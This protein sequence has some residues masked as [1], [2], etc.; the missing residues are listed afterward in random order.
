M[1]LEI[2][3]DGMDLWSPFPHLLG[4]GYKCFLGKIIGEGWLIFLLCF[5]DYINLSLA[6]DVFISSM[7]SSV[8]SHQGWNFKFFRNLNDRG[9]IDLSALLSLLDGFSL[10]SFIPD[11]RIWIANSSGVFSCKSYFDK[12]IGSPNLPI[13]LPSAMIWKASVPLKVHVF[14]WT[15]VHKRIN[16]F[17]PMR[18]FKEGGL[19]FTF[20]HGGVSCAKEMWRV[21]IICSHF[22]LW[23][24][25]CGRLFSL[26][27]ESWVLL[28]CVSRMFEIHGMQEFFLC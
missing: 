22:V 27:G 6:Y 10:S 18:C 24:Y 11:R 26:G 23:L 15:V 17:I 20:S 12:L 21:L 9:S 19:P 16:N 3:G 7:V 4:W 14:A 1:S 5:A 13:F 28:G 2:L 25:G 8:S